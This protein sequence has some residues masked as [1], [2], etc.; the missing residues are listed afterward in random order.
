MINVIFDMDDVI[1]DSERKLM[2]CWIEKS[3]EYGLDR[4][5]VIDT[6]VKCIGT[7]DRQT[8]EIYE[9]AFL[10][11]L[12]REKLDALW[13]ESMELFKNRYSDGKLPLK[14]GVKELLEFLKSKDVAVG[15]ASS[16]KRATVERQITEAGLR[17]YFRSIVGG[18]AVHISKP[19][20]EIYLLACQDLDVAPQETIAIEDSFNGIRAAS[21][22]GMRPIMVPDIVPPDREMKDL[23]EAI[24]ADLFEVLDI[25][26]SLFP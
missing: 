18:D 20:P 2:N 23:S 16:S 6:Y 9:N 14:D 7:N 11:K 3:A 26:K 1:F 4:K 25:M 10:N 19:N 12:G 24:C 5:A 17:D 21:A 13:D 8:M 22:A 15:I